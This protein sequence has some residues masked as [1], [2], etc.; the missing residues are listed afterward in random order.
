MKTGL[1]RLLALGMVLALLTTV[2]CGSTV[3]GPEGDW[4]L[5]SYGD[6]ETPPAGVEV[7]AKFEDDV[8]SGSAGCNRYQGSYETDGSDM[9]IG[10]VAATEM[11]CMDPEGVM[12]LEQD[13]LIAIS[14]SETFEVEDGELR[15]NYP[16]GV[17][18]FA[19]R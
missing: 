16:G 11:F 9:T 12:D 6:A 2:A 10:P 17:L 3:A 13:F 7:T 8:V 19:A 1:P 15:M 4:V 14:T 5:D 18:T